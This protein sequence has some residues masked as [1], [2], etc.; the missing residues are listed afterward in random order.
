MWPPLERRSPTGTTR[1]I[2]WR[3]VMLERV[4][5]LIEQRDRLVNA[6]ENPLRSGGIAVH[7]YKFNLSSNE[8][9]VETGDAVTCRR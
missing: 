7:T 3:R 8:H 1:S 5:D 4:R 6:V 9:T 2:A